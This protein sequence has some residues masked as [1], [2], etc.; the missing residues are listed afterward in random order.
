MLNRQVAFL[1]NE[2]TGSKLTDAESGIFTEFYFDRGLT[3]YRHMHHP[4]KNNK[5]VSLSAYCFS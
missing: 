3:V 5:R 4:A 1:V 2:L